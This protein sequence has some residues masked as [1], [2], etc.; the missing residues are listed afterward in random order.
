MEM[1]IFAACIYA[2]WIIATRIV[3]PVCRVFGFVAA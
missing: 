1:M 3:I 2:G